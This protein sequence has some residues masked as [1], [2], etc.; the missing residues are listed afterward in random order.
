MKIQRLVPTAAVKLLDTIDRIS[1]RL[2]LSHA[3][4]GRGRLRLNA[5]DRLV[6]GL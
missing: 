1:R 2:G 4:G 5:P 6:D 3:G